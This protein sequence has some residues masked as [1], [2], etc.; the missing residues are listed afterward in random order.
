MS[1][2]HIPGTVLGPE[3]TVVTTMAMVLLA[4]MELAAKRLFLSAWICR[5]TFLTWKCLPKRLG[6]H[7]DENLPVY[8][9]KTFKPYH[10]YFMSLSFSS[11]SAE[12]VF[13]HVLHILNL[14]NFEAAFGAFI[15]KPAPLLATLLR[16]WC[17][18]HFGKAQW[19][20]SVP[21]AIRNVFT[22]A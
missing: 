1:T 17:W 10:V 7:Q 4:L 9:A 8:N 13:S 12:K 11:N 21:T 16:L 22:Q 19:V 15:I 20:C 3:N 5:P 2:H 6:L 18:R 14:H